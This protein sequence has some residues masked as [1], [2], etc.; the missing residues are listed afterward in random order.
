[1]VSC[2]YGIVAENFPTAA[3]VIVGIFAA[4]LFT[5]LVR[6]FWKELRHKPG[7]APVGPLS[8]DE[9]TKARYKL[10]NPLPPTPGKLGNSSI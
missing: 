7:P 3:K 10:K 4:G 1:M 8:P 5:L 9:R 6:A 2:V